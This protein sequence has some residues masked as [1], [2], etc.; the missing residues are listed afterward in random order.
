MEQ[1][2]S[3]GKAY[4]A[5]SQDAFVS[6]DFRWFMQG[7]AQKAATE[8][9][10]SLVRTVDID[11]GKKRRAIIMLHGFSSTPAVYRL[12][13]PHL[14]RFDRILI[15][16]LPGHGRSIESFAKSTAREWLSS[17]EAYSR[18]LLN[19]YEE[20]EIMGL[21]M[22]GLI[23][24]ML[25]QHLPFRHA[26]LLAPALNLTMNITCSLKFSKVMDFIGFH[27]YRAAA[28]SLHQKKHLELAYR[29]LPMSTIK[30]ILNLVQTYHHE[31][32]KC[33]ADVLLGKYDKVVQSQEVEQRF[34]NDEKTTVHWLDNSDHIL[35]LDGDLSYIIELVN[36]ELPVY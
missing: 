5:T 24:A 25:C 16:R 3:P 17:A 26:F 10:E 19:H 23:A 12:I 21:S 35:P 9:D 20:V 13:Y 36:Q 27:Q 1:S 28:G 2:T 11:N 18:D 30:E 8:K 34:T 15:P 33:S 29:R 4:V 22:G 31:S 7:K 32:L 6:S 14:K